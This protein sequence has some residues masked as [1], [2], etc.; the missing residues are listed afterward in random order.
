[1]HFIYS[2]AC[3]SNTGLVDRNRGSAYLILVIFFFFWLFVKLTK[4]VCIDIALCVMVH[5]VEISPSLTPNNRWNSQSFEMN[6]AWKTVNHSIP[7]IT[8]ISDKVF[9][10]S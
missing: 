8:H 6:D 5:D 3:L 4:V 9:R 10:C 2:S 7:G 1:M